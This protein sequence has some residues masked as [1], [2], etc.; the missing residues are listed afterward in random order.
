MKRAR[1]ATIVAAIAL[2]AT[3]IGW[4][5]PVLTA[6][7]VTPVVVTI[8]F[9]DGTLDQFDARTVLSDHDMNATFF[10]NSGFIG[11]ADHMSRRQLELLASD[12]NEIG[13]HTV[14]HANI[15]PL[16]VIDAT[17]E[18]CDDHTP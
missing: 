8:G 6:H 12:G 9:D 14:D 17:A 3:S 1:R 2:I 10:I 16:S 18:V 13:G 4:S 7:A 5:Q 15:Q 11:D